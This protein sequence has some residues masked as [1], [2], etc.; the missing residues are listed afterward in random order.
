MSTR[1]NTIYFIPH[2]QKPKTKKAAYIRI[3]TTYQLNKAETNRVRWTVGRDRIIY[4]SKLATPTVDLSTVKIHLN[5]TISTKGEQY[6]VIDIKD[7]YLGTP[8]M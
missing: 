3:V 8:M 4:D 1:T 6:D 7:F 2:N 5:H